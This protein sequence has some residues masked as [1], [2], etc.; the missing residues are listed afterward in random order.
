MSR[1]VTSSRP[2]SP[3]QVARDA[4]ASELDQTLFVEAGAG[5]GKTTALVGRIV[6]LAERGVAMR[7]IAAIT[8]TEAAASELRDRVRAALEERAEESLFLTQ[9]AEDVD[10][11]VI[12]TLHSFAQRLVTD[13]PLETGLPPAIEVL[14]EI[15]SSL[16][17]E[18]RWTAFIDGLHND[19]SAEDLLLRA[20]A[21]GLKFDQA[22]VVAEVFD[23]QRDRLV[24]TPMAPPPPRAIDVQPVLHALRELA[25]LRATCSVPDDRLA[26]WL[27]R[28]AEV[29]ARL[30]QAD[31]GLDVLGV[32][33]LAQAENRSG[34]IFRSGKIGRK[35][36]WSD[37]AAARDA[38]EAAE[39][40]AAAVLGQA[41]AEI[42]AH[43]LYR[44]DLNTR[45]AAAD[46]FRRGRLLFHDL[47]VAARD[48]LRHSTPVRQAVAE[49]YRHL[50]I[51][52]FQDTDPIQVELAVLLAT[53]A[54]E[55]GDKPWT[56]LPLH[57][58][59]LFFV[60][61][62]KQSIYRFRRADIGLFLEVR[63]AVAAAPL[64][65][66][67]NF[68]SDPTI[69]AWI[70]ATFGA[71]MPNE[72]AGQAAYQELQA[73]RVIPAGGN[74]AEAAVWL[75][76]HEHPK[77]RSI[78][79]VREQEAQEL[80]A[81]LAEAMGTWVVS[82]RP[83]VAGGP[84]QRRPARWAD[85]AILLPT[86][87]ALPYLEQAFDDAD[88]PYRVESSSLV[89]G[90]QQVR[91][92]LAVLQ[93]I[94]DPT[95]EVALV[96]ALR[97]PALACSDDD[98]LGF[99]AANGSWDL[100]R[101]PPDVLSE[102]HPVVAGLRTL[103][104]LHE[105]R[106][107]VGVSSLVDRV[108]RDLAYFEL[109][110]AHRRPRDHWRRLRFVVDQARRFEDTPGA[111]L[112]GFLRW[113]ERQADDSARVREPVLPETDDDAVRIL[114]VHGS[115]GLEFP[116]VVVAGLNRTLEARTAAVLWGDDGRVQV[117]LGTFSTDGYETVKEQEREMAAKERHRLLYVATTRARDHLILS[118]HR[119][120][121]STTDASLLLEHASLGG[122]IHQVLP[123][124]TMRLR[125]QE[126][127]GPTLDPADQPAARQ[128]WDAARRKALEDHR[129]QPVVAATG[130][131][132]AL[133]AP[134]KAEPDTDLTPHRRGRAG[135]AVGRAVHATLQAVSLSDPQNLPSIAAAQAAAEGFPDLAT[136]VGRLAQSAV[137]SDVVRTAVRHRH[138]R[139]LYLAAPIGETTVEGFI[140]LLYDGPDGLVVVDYKTDRLD[141]DTE[142]EG[143][144]SRYRLQLATYALVI[145]EVLQRP[146][147]G[148]ALLYVRGDESRTRWVPDLPGAV[149]EI[150]ARLP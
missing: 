45:A 104:I 76:G 133:A 128:L 149:A 144:V 81:A 24:G 135:T 117:R 47:L 35:E 13:H 73:G 106:W 26:L 86:R 121:G 63:N 75:L 93:A 8:F 27:D 139:E 137:D 54:T 107:W 65:L 58:G 78:A 141:D 18:E 6:A 80:A 10:E 40:A 33:S 85:M 11:A 68:R 142:L 70:N 113:A 72:E 115:K 145:E 90:T 150:R 17:F 15:E 32:L 124:P 136:E 102:S 59:R 37:V 7:Q 50:L 100:T 69:L 60:G 74:E 130:V 97:S 71:L 2:A 38:T 122:A 23:D 39:D 43:L 48:V 51:D 36:N 14:D 112:R 119:K 30:T 132:A 62:P 29:A 53:T 99:R 111:T 89:W 66:S 83:A 146:V 55:V 120:A 147:V 84:E 42:L 67:A 41:R 25:V 52:E 87:T 88:V 140:D 82:D 4:V 44:M 95:D 1:R 79:E 127:E 131:A 114:T 92:L 91:D 31:G 138:W 21:T 19:P 77:D 46:R 103:R 116:V 5:T 98:L 20:F 28:V 12:S 108:V 16:E 118:V 9:A 109:A 57:P 105:E 94:D 56:E 49:R 101:Q 134:E 96:A 64:Q 34:A 22:R 61:D 110:V 126:P 143:S 148:A 125:S 129:R 123:T 3:D